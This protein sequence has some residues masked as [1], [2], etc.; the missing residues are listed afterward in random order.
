MIIAS[1]GIAIGVD[2]EGDILV[3]LL[4][5]DCECCR[6]SGF[7]SLSEAE[8]LAERLEF[9]IAEARVRKTQPF[10]VAAESRA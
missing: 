4:H 2:G 7:I 1:R 8:R 6:T 3:S 5:M 9:A 10:A